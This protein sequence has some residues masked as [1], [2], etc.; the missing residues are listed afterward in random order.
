[1]GP[2]H[3]FGTQSQTDET[4]TLVQVEVHCAHCEKVNYRRVHRIRAHILGDAA[5]ERT[6]MDHDFAARFQL[7]S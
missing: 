5:K 6:D 3:N 2:S 4:K 7:N 1:M